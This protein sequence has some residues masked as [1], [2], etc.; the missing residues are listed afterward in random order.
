MASK[1][2]ESDYLWVRNAPTELAT[3]FKNHG[4]I[5]IYDRAPNHI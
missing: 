1:N 4:N 5:F 3:T 2:M